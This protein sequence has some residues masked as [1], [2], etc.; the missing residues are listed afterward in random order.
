M[1]TVGIT[2]PVCNKGQVVVDYK[3]SDSRCP[4]CRTMVKFRVN[5]NTVMKEVKEVTV[6]IQMED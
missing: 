3:G 5:G 2:C 4:S 6:T 1:V